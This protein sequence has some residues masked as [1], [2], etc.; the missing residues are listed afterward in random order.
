MSHYCGI[1]CTNNHVVV[2]TDEEDK[3]VLEKRFNADAKDQ[4]ITGTK[5]VYGNG[6][7]ILSG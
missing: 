3:R 4:D 2:V 1:D 5:S 6:H 7:N